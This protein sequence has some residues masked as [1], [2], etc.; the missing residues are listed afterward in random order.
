MMASPLR[1]LFGQGPAAGYVAGHD[2]DRVV[3][4]D[5]ADDVGEPGAVQRAGEELRR[6]G[7]GSEDGQVAAGVDAGEQLAQQP[8]EP[9]GCVLGVAQ[10]PSA[11]RSLTAPSSSRSRD[12]VAWVTWMPSAASSSA[13]SVCERTARPRI[14]STIRACRPARVIGFV[15]TDCTGRR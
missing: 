7:R 1:Q 6:P 14:R 11:P 2:E 12:R 4:G 8:D 13:S 3:A 15:M 5:G 9:G 10:R